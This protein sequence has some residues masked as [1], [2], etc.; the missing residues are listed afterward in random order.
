MPCQRY[1]TL[2][3]SPDLTIGDYHCRPAT[4]AEGSEEQSC[5][6]SIALL[7]T[8]AFTRRIGR[9]RQIAD[10]NWAVFFH[11][12]VT[13][14]VSHPTDQGD[15]CSVFTPSP[16]LL[17]E[18]LEDVDPRATRG[19]SPAVPVDQAPTSSR[20]HLIHHLLFGSVRR[21]ADGLE[22]EELAL[23][24]VRAVLRDAA[25]FRGASPKR[26]G[27]TDTHAAHVELVERTKLELARRVCDRPTL[28][29]VAGAVHASPY[30]LSRVFSRSVGVPMNRYMDRLRLRHA[31]DR[32]ADDRLPITSVALDA[33]YYDHS[34]FTNAFRREF[35]LTPS[36][37]RR[38]GRT[39]LREMSKSFQV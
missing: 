19:A 17:A 5:A 21:G 30:H 33:G 4:C 8:G 24:L 23:R 1:T 12:D 39:T 29:D 35:G 10:A 6:P 27:R 37:C 26:P 20:V 32:L 18:V 31:L 34:H 3:R 7:R 36:R 16:R 14:H 13:Y 22:I 38:E 15:D 9:A 2:F 25:R 11:P 28:S